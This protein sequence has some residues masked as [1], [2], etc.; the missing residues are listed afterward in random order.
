MKTEKEASSGGGRPEILAPSVLVQRSNPMS[1]KSEWKM[2]PEDY[3]YQQELARAA[4]ADML[5][6]SE[7]VI[8]N[9]LHN[10]SSSW[11]KKAYLI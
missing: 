1:G 10:Q 9:S 7:R 11:R 2:Q 8:T 6:D 4:F 5:H 3:D